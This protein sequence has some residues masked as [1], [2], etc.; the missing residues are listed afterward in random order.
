MGVC[1]SE[2]FFLLIPGRNGGF[3]V[4]MRGRSIQVLE[5]NQTMISCST[6]HKHIDVGRQVLKEFLS[7]EDMSIHL[8]RQLLRASPWHFHQVGRWVFKNK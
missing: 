8:T 7:R 6:G 5:N 4:A 3:A 2:C 1:V